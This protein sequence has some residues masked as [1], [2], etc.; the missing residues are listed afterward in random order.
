MNHVISVNKT[1]ERTVQSLNINENPVQQNI[2]NEIKSFY[3]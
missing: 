1:W 3:K 2:I